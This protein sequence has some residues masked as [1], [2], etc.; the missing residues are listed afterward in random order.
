MDEEGADM[1]KAI[2]AV[3]AVLLSFGVMG[4]THADAA[5]CESGSLLAPVEALIHGV[6]GSQ[7]DVVFGFVN[8]ID[9]IALAPAGLTNTLC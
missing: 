1:R 6:V 2:V 4:F 9:G 7:A 3:V 8:M 5:V